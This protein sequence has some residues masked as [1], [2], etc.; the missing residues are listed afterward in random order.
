MRQGEWVR[1]SEREGERE[2]EV[3]RSA[4]VWGSSTLSLSFS[5][6]FRSHPLVRNASRMREDLRPKGSRIVF[7]PFRF[8]FHNFYHFFLGFETK[9]KCCAS[10]ELI[11]CQLHGEE[12][13]DLLLSLLLL[14][15]ISCAA[16]GETKRFMGRVFA[17]WLL[18]LTSRWLCQI[19][20]NYVRIF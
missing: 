14:P 13:E 19:V 12:A 18:L 10:C 9:C 4:Y 16:W 8:F 6:F 15:Q 3:E 5:C 11:N 7:N 1:E 2:G 20:N 17:P